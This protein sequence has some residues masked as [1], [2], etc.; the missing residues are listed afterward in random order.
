MT[1]P[2]IKIFYMIERLAR[3]GTELHL[4]KLIRQLDRER[5]EPVL[6]CL[7]ASKTDRSLL[8]AGVRSYLLNARWNLL[9]PQT[10]GIYRQLVKILRKEKPEI[11]HSF[12][13]VSNIIGPFAAKKAGVRKVLVTRDRMGI[14]WQATA[15]HRWVQRLANQR[16][17]LILCKTEAMGREISQVEHTS[18]DKI[19]VVPNGVETERFQ[20]RVGEMH[21]SRTCLREMYGVPVDGPLILAVGNLKPVKGHASLVEAATWLREKFPRIQIAIVGDGES[22]AD[23]QEQ[24]TARALE[25]NVLLPGSCPDVRPWMRAADLQVAPSLSEGMPN[26]VLEAMAMGLPLVLSDIPGHRE[27]AKSNAWYFE[28][29][30]PVELAS[31]IEAA[32]NAPDKRAEFSRLGMERAHG[33]MSLET[34]VKRVET[35]YDEVLKKW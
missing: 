9:N 15:A 27:A 19:R 33:E 29:G 11:L 21:E 28:A 6:C 20:F 32:L 7:N 4:T 3:A 13:F 8:P 2:K 12:L 5:F 31:A 10:F 14:E 34:M 24:I 17:T 18:W 26:A 30:N 23:L 25:Q 1:K 35:I 16:T 22:R